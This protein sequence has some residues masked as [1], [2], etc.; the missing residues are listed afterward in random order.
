[1]K[2]G[3]IFGAGS[4]GRG[5]LG[6]IFAQS[7]LDVV[8]VDVDS[9]IV[10]LLNKRRSYTVRAISNEK[11]ES[12]E[13]SGIR[14]LNGTNK[15]EVIVELS[16]ADVI[17]TAV[18]VENIPHIA[19]VIAHGLKRRFESD[20]NTPV[21][22][23]ICENL[24][25]A[26]QVFRNFVDKQ[27]LLTQDQLRQVGF[28]DTS[29][30]RMVPLPTKKTNKEDPLRIYA[31]FYCKLQVNK[32]DIKGCTE[33]LDAVESFSPFEYYKERKL[34]VHNLGHS[35]ASYWGALYKLE[36]IWQCMEHAEIK[37]ITQDAMH[38]SAKAIARKYT[39]DDA[40]LINHVDDLM[41]RFYNKPLNDTVA[42]GC[43]APLRKLAP[44][45]RFIGAV[46]NCAGQT[47][48]YDC[49]LESI[50]AALLYEDSQDS[51]AVAM[52]NMIKEQGV[53][54]FLESYCRLSPQESAKCY[55]KYKSYN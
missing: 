45:D 9:R 2:K 23:L 44:E 47:I 8:F 3:L 39:V 28:V 4:I 51:G 42:R 22:I 21:D 32:D 43:R 11:E 20:C 27:N 24:M 29:I 13:I 12:I 50:A 38:V 30:G 34:F 40:D 26:P 14:A 1:M 19:E 54:G 18:G 16:K 10:D 15:K 25:N 41:S 36:Y 31:E 53:I 46:R 55:L 35:V 49:L 6:Q 33:K 48:A 7:G 37:T 5:L 52:Q 17:A